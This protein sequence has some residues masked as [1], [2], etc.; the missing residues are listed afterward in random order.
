MTLTP[1]LTAAQEQLL[2]LFPPGTTLDANSELLIGGCRATELAAAFG[3]PALFID[4]SALRARARRYS[5]GLAARRPKSPG[6]GGSQ[7]LPPTPRI[8]QRAAQ[9][10]IRR[11]HGRNPLTG[12]HRMPALSF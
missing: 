4:E 2:E 8:G 11:G 10:E 3:T 6:V 5:D 12:P 9:P 1:T 7:A